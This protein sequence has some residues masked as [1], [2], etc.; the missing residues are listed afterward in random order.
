MELLDI[1]IFMKAKA[2][3]NIKPSEALKT[4]EYL[5]EKYPKDL[6]V[7]REI[8]S[9]YFSRHKFKKAADLYSLLFLKGKDDSDLKYTIAASIFSK[10]YN[11]NFKCLKLHEKSS[12]ESLKNIV[13]RLFNRAN[14]KKKI[15]KELKSTLNFGNFNVD[16]EVSKNNS[17]IK[18]IDSFNKKYLKALN[19]I[20]NKNIFAG[21]ETLKEIYGISNDKKLLEFFCKKQHFMIL[22]T[23]SKECCFYK[24]YFRKSIKIIKN[25]LCDTLLLLLLKECWSSCNEFIEMLLNDS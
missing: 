1:L 18:E 12:N 13:E 21:I 8:A 14:F 24:P 11:L 4:L 2:K 17:D 5:R 25:N 15:I 7:I 10:K 22:Y 16:S 23:L 6:N 9:L 3:K 19:Q 20:K